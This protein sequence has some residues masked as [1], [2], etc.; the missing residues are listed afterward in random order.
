ML[1]IIINSYACCPNMGS[2]PGMGWNWI[3]H[4]AKYCELYVISEGEF[5]VKVETWMIEL[6]ARH[7]EALKTDAVE[8]SGW[9]SLKNDGWQG[10]VCFYWNPVSV[11]VRKMCW[12][13][14]DWR[15]YR[16]YEKW[17][18]KTADIA[19]KIIECNH[20]DILHQLNMIGFREPGYLWQVSKESGVPFVWGPVD[21]KGS[22][23]MAYTEGAP[24]KNILF[25]RIKNLIT[26][27][28][29]RFERRVHNAAQ[30]ASLILGANSN[31]VRNV[32]A[33]FN[34]DCVLMNETGCSTYVSNEKNEAKIDICSNEEKECKTYLKSRNKLSLLWVGKFDFRKQLSLAICIIGKI[35]NFNCNLHIVGEGDVH[36]LKKQITDLEIED[37]IILHGSI[38][39]FEVQKLMRE[40]DVL[41]F[42]SVAEGTPH[43]VLEAISNRLPIICFDTCGQGDCVDSSVGIKIP[44]STPS[45]SVKDFAGKI[46]YLYNHP[47]ELQRMS[48]NCKKRAGELS[49][50]KKAKQII[51]LYESIL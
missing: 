45:Q 35:K 33:Y 1:K 32:N 44:L 24:I 8:S 42:T 9:Y 17:Q 20:I 25:L 36:S 10:K 14:G 16:H 6:G 4:L 21:A 12:N 49:W 19:R 48:E 28:Q 43:V 3:I 47:E 13:Q 46:E 23:P 41:L 39:H 18:R 30:Q 37:R 51:N 40:T 2:E 38:S 31:S 5:R 22:F 26:D 15:F 7:I 50:D 11:D 27:L 34:K 29:L